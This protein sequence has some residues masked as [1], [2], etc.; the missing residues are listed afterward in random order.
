MTNNAHKKAAR[1]HQAETGK[2][3][4]Q[5][6]RE[7]DTTTGPRRN[8][9]A[10]LGVD[11]DGAAVTLDLNEPSRGGVGP[12]C[13][14]TGRTGSGKTVLVERIARS[15]AHD[16]RTAPEI[17]VHGRLTAA[18]P[19]SVRLVEGESLTG[20]LAQLLD[21]RSRDGNVQASP[22]V[23]LIDNCDGWLLQSSID[24]FTTGGG[25]LRRLVREGRALGIHLVLTMQHERP[26][27]AL[28]GAGSA[29]ADNIS[30][31]IRLK[32]RTFS[33]L[34]MGEGLLQ[35][36]DGFDVHSCRPSDRDIRFRFEAV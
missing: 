1:Q 11:G 4:S 21:D 24:R 29:V 13:F 28:G 12:H 5:A 10:H 8:L 2:P 7:V 3:Y 31:G 6:L 18:L 19:S 33:E 26:E 17:F 16:Q 36:S 22:V 30:T 23:V 25:T 9:V 34:H 20:I 32:S 27:A 14:I 35:C 15:L